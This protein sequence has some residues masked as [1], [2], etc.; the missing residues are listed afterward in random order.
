MSEGFS[1]AWLDRREPADAAARSQPL[2]E[3]LKGWCAVRPGELRVVDLGAG[4]GANLRR[5]APVLGRPQTWTLIEHDPTLTAAGAARLAGCQVTWRYR[6]LDLAREL[7]TLAAEPVDLI[8]A[9]AL[10]DLVSQA[11]LDRLVALRSRTGAAL[12]VDLSFDGR[13]SW[14]PLDASDALVIE[15]VDR[16]QRSDKGFGPALGSQAAM[17]LLRGLDGSRGELLLARSDW[18]LG[19][20]ATVLQQELLRGHAEAA[21]AIAPEHRDEIE[22]WQQRRLRPIEGGRSALLVGHLDL[23]FLPEQP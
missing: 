2:L 11:W 19:P 21:V 3:R 9:S 18:R 22:G 7:E 14:A 13:V 23:L 6:A 15:L 8:T 5:T 1:A 17:A 20:E 16:H 10:I 4:T 12:A